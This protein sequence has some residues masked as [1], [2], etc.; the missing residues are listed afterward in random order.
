MD[1]EIKKQQDKKEFDR[2]I[3]RMIRHY[4]CK[5]QVDKANGVNLKVINE[6]EENIKFLEDL[7]DGKIELKN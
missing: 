4:Q 1:G 7:R 3:E 5:M 6:Y 2:I